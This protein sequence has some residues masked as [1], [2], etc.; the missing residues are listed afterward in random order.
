MP[1]VFDKS[2]SEEK[3]EIG[4]VVNEEWKSIFLF[5]FVFKP[6]LKKDQDYEKQIQEK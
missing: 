1:D 6:N 3:D 4:T 2:I 5:G